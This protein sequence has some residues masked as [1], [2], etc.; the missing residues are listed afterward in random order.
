MHQKYLI[1][2]TH[3]P[4]DDFY[5]EESLEL[6]L[7]SASLDLE[8]SVLFLQNAV[9]QLLDNQQYELINRNLFAKTLQALEL[10]ALKNIYVED[11]ML[12]K[13]L[14]SDLKTRSNINII[15]FSLVN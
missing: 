14:I 12:E 15:K 13:L 6:I 4:V 5:A 11:I 3:S 9:F 2:N 7:S 10:F 1:I 8:V